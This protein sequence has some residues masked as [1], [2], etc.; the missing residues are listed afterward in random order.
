MLNR[1]RFLG[2]I[3]ST[4]ILLLGSSAFGETFRWSYQSNVAG[5]DVMSSGDIPTRNLL[6]NVYEA[7]T[8]LDDELKP[9]PALAE[10]WAVVSPT[11]WR[12]NLRK[13]VVFH[14]G[15]PMTADDVLFSYKR[16]TSATSDVKSRINSIKAIRKVDAHTV[17]IET[18]A[19]SPTL[20]A[21]LTYLDIFSERWATANNA[22]DPAPLA[23]RVENYATRN[24]NGSGPFRIVSFDSAKGAELVPFEKWWDTKEHNITRAV[25]TPITVD[26]TRVAALLANQVDM[27]FPLP[28][29]DVQRVQASPR[30]ELLMGPQDLVIFLGM[31][32]TRDELL[33][34]NI[35]GKNPFK[36]V[37]V[38]QAV[39]Q[40][41]DA[42]LIRERTMRGA[43][44]STGA[45]T[46]K[47]AFGWQ[48]QFDERLP[49]DPD[50]AKKLLNEAGYPNGFQVTID[51]PNDRYVNDEEICVALA[52]MLARVGIKLDV[53]AQP[54]N[55]YFAKLGKKDSSFY[56]HGWSTA[57]DPLMMMR[58]LIHSPTGNLG[59]W[60]VG[61]YSNKRVDELL[62]ALG[63]EIDQSKRAIMIKDIYDIHRG[64]IGAIPLHVQT[65][66]WGVRKGV[67]VRQRPDD[68]LDL[69]YVKVMAPG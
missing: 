21:D 69:R 65:L 10:S 51:C 23:Q 45:L 31:D 63:Q 61:G 25:F 48:P 35:K 66:A 30:H 3:A 2:A 64:E 62:Q 54:R 11:V 49:Y 68:F 47:F 33:Y 50:A 43:A 60:N 22:V 12:F 28:Q 16:A 8:R 26:A 53:L 46:T 32:Q 18:V 20:L 4:G 67:S 59:S 40:A 39:Y 56:I 41:I 14:D 42:R 36:D 55:L 37:R 15:A 52:S 7:L 5:L 34:S 19:P 29:Q 38:R 9:V 24:A 13:N 1:A 27:I 57:P 58:F 17:E 44:V 6:R